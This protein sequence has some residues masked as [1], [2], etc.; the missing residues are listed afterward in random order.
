M[1]F[2]QLGPTYYNERDRGLLQRMEAFYAEAITTNLS[3]WTEAD[4]DTR[5][6]AGDQ[7]IFNSGG[8]AFIAPE[9]QKPVAH[10]TL[11]VRI[12][13]VSRWPETTRPPLTKT[14]HRLRTRP[15]INPDRKRRRRAK[16]VTLCNRSSLGG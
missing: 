13:S 10:Q 9:T 11:P 7:T 14:L 15:C 6:Y 5:F 3:F 8:A 12:G 2:P 1:I 16:H 4:I